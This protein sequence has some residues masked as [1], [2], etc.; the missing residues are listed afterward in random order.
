MKW[1][2][3][4]QEFDPGGPLHRLL[5]GNDQLIVDPG[6]PVNPLE[7]DIWVSQNHDPII[8]NCFRI[9]TD[10][11]SLK[12]KMWNG[13]NPHERESHYHAWHYYE[14]VPDEYLNLVYANPK[15]VA[16]VHNIDLK[17]VHFL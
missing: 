10:P 13:K 12:S 17:L 14:N 4:K 16:L 7:K 3:F 15:S 8:D 6:T 9:Y 5:K 1:T 2:K 11:A